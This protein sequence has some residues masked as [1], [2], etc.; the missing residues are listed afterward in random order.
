MTCWDFAKKCWGA[1][2]ELGLGIKL[3]VLKKMSGTAWIVLTAAALVFIAGMW[4][5]GLSFA[6]DP[7]L[8]ASVDVIG[9]FLSFTIAANTLVR[10]RGTRDRMPLVLAIGFGASGLLELGATLELFRHFATAGPFIE[11][12]R[13]SWMQ[14]RTLLAE[15]MLLAIAV[16]QRLP[17]QRDPEREISSALTLVGTVGYLTSALYFIFSGE[18]LIRTRTLL[19]RPW[20]MLPAALFVLAAVGFH[21]RLRKVSSSFDRALAVSAW[22]NVGCHLIM[23]ESSRVLDAPYALAQTLRVSSYAV[24][25]G[26][27]LLDNSRLF[28]QVHQLAATDPLTGLANYRRLV[29]VLDAEIERSSRTGRGFAV[30]LLDLDHLKVI[31]D[32]HGHLVGSRALRRLAEVLRVHCR[33]VD[34]AA[35]YG[36]DEFAVVLPETGE[37]AALSAATRIRERLSAQAERPKLSVSIG[38]AVYPMHGTTADRLLVSADHALYEMKAKREKTSNSTKHP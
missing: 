7:S 34:T 15:T 5:R 21:Q 30:M 13:M 31:N 10:F 38:V 1:L 11:R 35:R 3:Q 25:L 14:S 24:V 17:Q 37:Q 20:E 2:P 22:M 28:M 4:L 29:D 6:A 16:E 9:V 26:G 12:A 36:G 19:A 8:S 18:P 32:Q 33:S 27:T 23:L